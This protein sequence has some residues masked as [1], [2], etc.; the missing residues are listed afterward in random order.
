MGA[1]GG[2]V[3]LRGHGERGRYGSVFTQLSSGQLKRKL[4]DRD[5]WVGVEM[6]GSVESGVTC[7]SGIVFIVAKGGVI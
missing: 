4:L 5:G 1:G 3:G 2:E 7:Y 6:V